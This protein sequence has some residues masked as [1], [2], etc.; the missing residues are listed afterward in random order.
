MVPNLN[1]I[2]NLLGWICLFVAV[3]GSFYALAAAELVRRFR[4]S[5]SPRSRGCPAVTILKPLHGSEPHL[6]ESLRSFCRQTYA[7]PVQIVFGVRDSADP[8]VEVVRRLIGDFPDADL[9]LVIDSGL[10]GTNRKI[11]NLI[12]M[13]KIIRHDVLVIADSDIQVSPDYLSLVV[14]ALEAP[15]IGMATCLYCGA[16]ERG[17]LSN[18][19]AMA[20]DY[21]FL[22]SVLVGLKLGM[23]RPSFGSTIAL[24]RQMLAQIGGFQAFAEHL[25]DDNAMGEAVRR[26]GAKVAI[27]AMLVAH[28]C[29]KQ[30]PG[31]LLNRE[32]RWARTIRA[33]NAR[34]FL[35]SLMVHPLPFA[36][37]AVLLGD[38]DSFGLFIVAGVLLC[39]HILER[40]IDSAIGNVAYRWPLAPL[41]DMLSF[42]V[43]VASFFVST[44]K[45][46]GQRYKVRANGTLVSLRTSK[47]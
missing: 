37:V 20:I 1:Y 17:L 22:P 24:R 9:S 4:Q 26:T 13:S 39:R 14:G 5:R 45:W 19:A 31:E 12:N 33:V 23:A 42:L 40:Q 43:H 44:V 11:A 10:Q 21:H 34:G 35:A 28:V 6:Y 46:R 32:L 16:P 27:P 47:S 36:L 3:M 25:A 15:G 8:A 29:P 7:G 41:R 38:F 18:L 2:S 30:N